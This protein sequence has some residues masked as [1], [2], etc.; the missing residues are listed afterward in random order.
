MIHILQEQM[1]SSSTKFVC[2]T[3]ADREHN[4]KNPLQIYGYE[5]AGISAG[6]MLKFKLCEVCPIIKKY[7]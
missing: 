4:R 5:G 1:A 7:A 6:T 2:H 3:S